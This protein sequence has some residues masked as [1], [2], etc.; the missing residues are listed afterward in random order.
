M[1]KFPITQHILKKKMFKKIY[2]TGAIITGTFSGLTA[3]YIFH[4]DIRPFDKIP[5]SELLKPKSLQDIYT[6][7][8]ATLS[9][10]ICIQKVPVIIV[11][12]PISYVLTKINSNETG[13]KIMKTTICGIGALSCGIVGG[14]AWPILVPSIGLYYAETKL[15]IKLC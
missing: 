3:G 10:S 1:I 11:V 14:F 5:N 7:V 15:G 4:N 6:E 12:P 13:I 2:K 9:G 8:N